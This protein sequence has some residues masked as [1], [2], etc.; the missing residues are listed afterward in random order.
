MGNNVQPTTRSHVAL[1]LYRA[2]AT[3]QPLPVPRVVALEVHTT[4]TLSLLGNRNLEELHVQSVKLACRARGLTASAQ[5][6]TRIR[7][8]A[9]TVGGA[10]SLSSLRLRRKTPEPPVRRAI[11]KSATPLAVLLTA[12][13]TLPEVAA[14]RRV[15][16]VHKT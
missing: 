4:T 10:L 16:E 1:R 12:F 8:A 2:K 13:I 9:R 6:S 3:G 14:A 7:N 5:A 15:E 11:H